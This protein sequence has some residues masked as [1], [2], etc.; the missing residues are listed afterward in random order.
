MKARF[1]LQQWPNPYELPQLFQNRGQNTAMTTFV[2]LY[3]CGW[4][5]DF[6]PVVACCMPLS[7]EGT[8]AWFPA[9]RIGQNATGKKNQDAYML[10]SHNLEL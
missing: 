10:L 6:M 8:A 2:R 5:E 3:T 1:D 7:R 4:I 9:F